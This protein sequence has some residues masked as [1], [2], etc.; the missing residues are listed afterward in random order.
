MNY[1][2]YSPFIL[3]GFIS[4]LLNL[5][6]HW[7]GLFSLIETKLY[8]YRFKLRGPISEVRDIQTDVVLVEID[9]ESYKLIPDSYPYSRGSVWSNVIRNLTDAEAKVIVFDIMFDS[10][11]HS[12]KILE[13]FLNDECNNCDIYNGDELFNE[14]VEYANSN[15]TNI[16]LASKIAYDLN[17]IPSDFIVEPNDKIISSSVKMGIVNQE[18]DNIDYLIKRYPIFYKV[19]AQP[20]NIY[21]SLAVQSALSYYNV[22]DYRIKQD[23]DNGIFEIGEISISTFGKEASFLIN[24]YGP[25][26]SIFNTFK[27]YPLYQIIDDKNYNLSD[28][29]EDDDWMDKYIDPSSIY[30]SKFGHQKSPFKNKIVIIGSSL[31]EDN[32]F[33]LTPYYNYNNTKSLMPGL[34]LHANAIQQILDADYLNMPLSSLKLIDK[35]FIV[36]FLILFLLTTFSLIVCNRKS[37]IFSIILI[38]LSIIIWFSFS[39]GLFINDQFWIFK[40]MLNAIFGFNIEYNSIARNGSVL[41]PVFYPIASIMLTFGVNLAYRFLN[42]QKDKNFLKDTFGKYVSPDLI[43]EMYINKSYPKL[44]G[45]SGV[46]TAFFSD[47]ESFSTIAEKMTSSKLVKLLNEF[48]SSQTQIILK[49]KGTLDKYEGDAILAFYGAPV[50]FEKHS[51]AAIDSGIM[52]QKNLLELR[53]KWKNDKENW[54][55][56]VYNM[57]MRIGINTGEM[58]TGNM[59]SQYHMNYTMMGDVVNIAARLESSAKH[60]G[61]Y[62]H[63]TESTLNEAGVDNYL[64][65]YLDRIQFA[66]KTVW[67]QTVEIID[68][69]TNKNKKILKLINNFQKGLEYYYNQDWDNALNCFEESNTYETNNGKNDINPSKVFIERTL[70][71]KQFSPRKG[72]RGAFISKAK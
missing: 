33:V 8:D 9:D 61:I 10:Y 43:D 30:Y 38:F 12:S 53:K 4:I 48:L 25:T 18:A 20:D 35:S 34:E 45:E 7:V 59:G 54:P 6:L 26:S 66:G 3:I 1:K 68:Y 14:A 52:L 50:Y 19:S 41:V 23:V 44:G 49:Y 31:E 11:D 51:K 70:E 62:F 69:S 29:K 39:M 13:K 56:I 21:L 16:V 40:S 17:R 36:Q 64:W 42:E 37:I 22:E 63:V 27:R 2:K 15:G 55:D 58:V 57:N 5:F 32:D 46:R 28:F 67:H 65:R 72:W 24:Y 60:Y 47:I 71:F